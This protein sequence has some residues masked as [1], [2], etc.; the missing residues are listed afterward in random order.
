M[1]WD[2]SPAAASAHKKRPG[3]F[4]FANP[5]GKGDVAAAG[6]LPFLSVGDGDAATYR[7]LL[8]EEDMSAQ[9]FRSGPGAQWMPALAL[10]GGKVD[11]ADT[12]WLGTV[13]R[14]LNEETG[15]L[16]STH[17]LEDVES[18]DPR[19]GAWS[20][21]AARMSTYVPT[22]K[23]QAAFYP[24]PEAHAQEW[25]TLPARYA[26]R[27]GG[28]LPDGARERSATRL[29]WVEMAK[30]KSV[31]TGV[32]DPKGAEGAAWAARPARAGLGWAEGSP[33]PEVHGA[34]RANGEAGDEQAWG[35]RPVLHE[36]GGRPEDCARRCNLGAVPCPSRGRPL[37]LK[38]EL[39]GSLAAFMSLLG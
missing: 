14:E 24:V 2:R 19:L 38:R 5:H 32:E 12:H 17:A 20:D 1:E 21:R 27:F 34:K 33:E 16:L 39:A 10:F 18:F 6:L 11:R 9:D 25:L 15:G 36:C 8:A 37:P 7:V 22:A 4:L 30:N 26:K 28:E 29:H 3:R 35:L 31:K 13:A 23:Y